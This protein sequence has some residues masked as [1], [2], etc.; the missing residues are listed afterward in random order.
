MSFKIGYTPFAEEF[1][2]WT[3][4]SSLSCS[5]VRR[6]ALPPTCTEV[7]HDTLPPDT[8]DADNVVSWNNFKVLPKPTPYTTDLGPC[9][10]LL[11][12]NEKMYGVAHIMP[13][14]PGEK[15]TRALLETMQEGE[16]ETKIFLVGGEK[17]PDPRFNE[18]AP[19]ESQKQHDKIVRV[20][21]QFKDVSLEGDAFACAE[22]K[23]GFY[24]GQPQ[25]FL[26]FSDGRKDYTGASGISR[27]GFTPKGDPYAVIDV[28]FTGYN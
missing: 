11:A 3:P 13:S 26:G 25:P 22:W 27:T 2:K 19:T 21:S 10:A 9:I 12:H 6:E 8:F 7:P 18:R 5:G 17:V 24:R 20:I 14:G 1:L 23:N 4:P 15:L 28:K 16:G